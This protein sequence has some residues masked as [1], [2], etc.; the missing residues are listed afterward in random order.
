MIFVEPEEG[1]RGQEIA[2]FVAAEVEDQR[3]PILVLAL[4]RIGVLVEIGAVEL[5][6]AVRVLR[7][8][9]RAPNP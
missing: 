5:R 8:M 6:Q 1:V 7:K 3:A 2:H 4:A 9:R